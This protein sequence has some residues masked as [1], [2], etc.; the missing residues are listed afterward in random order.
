MSAHEIKSFKT[1]DEYVDKSDKKEKLV[2]KNKWYIFQSVPADLVS[3]A[4]IVII[5]YFSYLIYK[6]MP[7]YQL[8]ALEKFP[9]IHFPSYYETMPSIYLLVL[10]LIVSK[11]FQ[12]ISAP[13]IFSKLNKDYQDSNDP[14]LGRIY[15]KKVANNI[16]KCIFYTTSTIIGYITLKDTIYLDRWTLGN[17]NFQDFVKQGSPAILNFEKPHLLDFYYNFNLAYA[18]FEFYLLLSQPLQS[19]FLLMFIHHI[20]TVS[21]VLFSFVSNLSSIGSVVFF[22]HYYGDVYSTIVRTLIHLNVPDSFKGFCGFVFLVNFAFT[23]MVLYGSLILFSYIYLSNALIENSLIA[24]MIFIFLLNALW[25][26]L[27]SIKFVKYMMTGN[28]DEIY[29][30]KLKKKN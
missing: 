9:E 5:F 21:L 7:R 30:L 10:F 15:T 12:K 26:I 6:D 25:V 13:F 28:I 20:A 16:Y 23:R 8:S 1:T 18:Y 4:F 24:F 14:E 11:I 27:I 22:I 2:S 19:D 3:H 29:K 17:G